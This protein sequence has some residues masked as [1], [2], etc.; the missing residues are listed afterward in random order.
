[1]ASTSTNLSVNSVNNEIKGV[2]N[3]VV[4]DIVSVRKTPIQL[5][6]QS[7]LTAIQQN[8]KTYNA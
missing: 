4:S 6:Q 5:L 7:N 2:V 3:D 8:L 1:M